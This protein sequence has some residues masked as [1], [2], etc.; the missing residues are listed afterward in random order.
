MRLPIRR[1]EKP[2]GYEL[3][4]AHTDRY[5]GK[6]LHVNPG[7]ALS[8]QYHEKK[9]ETLYLAEGE[10]ELVVEEDGELRSTTLRAGESYRI[11][12]FTRHRMVGGRGRVRHHRGFDARAGRRRAAGGPVWPGGVGA[13]CSRASCSPP[14]PR[15]RSRSSRRRPS[16]SSQPP[17]AA[18][19]PAAEPAPRRPTGG[20]AR[21]TGARSRPDGHRHRARRGGQRRRGHGGGLRGRAGAPRHRAARH[22]EHHQPEPGQGQAGRKAARQAGAQAGRAGERLRRPQRLQAEAGRRSGAAGRASCGSAGRTWWTRSPT[23]RATPTCS[24]AASTPRPIRTSATAGSSRTGTGCSTA[25]GRC[26]RRRSGG[27]RR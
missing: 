9:D 5:V 2:W 25:S 17:E 12:P 3:I 4:F 20:R 23:W 24:A 22:P 1:V 18:T 21:G 7:E 15:R 10:V 27:A 16:R 26:G 8:L 13:G 6:I 19:E 11:V 14:A